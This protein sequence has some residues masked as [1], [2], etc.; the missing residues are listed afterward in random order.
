[1]DVEEVVLPCGEKRKKKHLLMIQGSPYVGYKKTLLPLI[2]HL[3]L[4]P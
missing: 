1:M 2:G 3:P 4:Q